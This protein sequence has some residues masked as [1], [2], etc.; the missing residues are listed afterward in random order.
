MNFYSQVC[1]LLLAKKLTSSQYE[2]LQKLI[3]AINSKGEITD[4]NAELYLP[5]VYSVKEVLNKVTYATLEKWLQATLEG[6]RLIVAVSHYDDSYR[7]HV[8]L[9]QCGNTN[10]FEQFPRA[11][12]N[13]YVFRLYEIN[14]YYVIELHS[15]YDG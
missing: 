14:K 6:R 7:L 11:G 15:K 13:Y 1:H 12:H 4:I 5:E 9:L 2:S 3:N 10:C 8:S